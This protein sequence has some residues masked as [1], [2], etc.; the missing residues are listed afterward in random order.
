MTT[1][2]RNN[3][4]DVLTNKLHIDRDTSENIEQGLYDKV[5]SLNDD[6]KRSYI[7]EFYR[8]YVNLFNQELMDSIENGTVKPYD[9]VWMK[10]Y[11]MAPQKWDE[12][13]HR[14]RLLVENSRKQVPAPN[15]YI[16]TCKC[17]SNECY[18]Y[19]KQTRSGDEAPTKVVIC[20]YC[21][22]SWRLND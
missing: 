3:A 15:T 16:Y 22:R 13:R 6:T 8:I 1:N 11:E 14:H 17:G 21:L 20:T 19:D 10:P 4:I 9:I 2:I 12:I 7:T 5:L 18:Q